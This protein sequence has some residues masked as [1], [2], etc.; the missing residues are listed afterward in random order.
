M[1]MEVGEDCACKSRARDSLVIEDNRVVKPKL[2]EPSATADGK[3]L[4][5]KTGQQNIN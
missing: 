2:G 4:C 1:A 5:Q 3:E